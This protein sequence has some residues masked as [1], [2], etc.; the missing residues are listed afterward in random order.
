M[1]YNYGL[2]CVIMTTV[3]SLVG[4]L[5]IQKLVKKT[6]RSS[7]IILLLASVIAIAVVVIPIH[8]IF[9]IIKMDILGVNIWKFEDVCR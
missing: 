5:I 2:A 6:G 3:G 4:T 7:I 9:Q 1:N 8:T